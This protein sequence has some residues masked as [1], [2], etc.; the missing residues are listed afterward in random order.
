[1]SQAVYDKHQQLLRLTLSADHKYRLYTPLADISPLI[2]Q[3]TLLQEDQY[4]YWHTGINPWALIKAGWQTYITQNRQ[5]GDST[6][7][8]QLARIYFKLN[9]KNLRGKLWQILRA[10]QLEVF[11]TRNQILEAYLNLAPYGG[12]IEG[13]GAASLVYFAKP[14]GKVVL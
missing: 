9:S 12:N 5:L 3:G 10:V 1:F 13:V 11:Y 8:M 14:A 6:N 7:T 2:I 4:F